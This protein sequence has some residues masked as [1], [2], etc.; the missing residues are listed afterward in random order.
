MF[1]NFQLIESR[2]SMIIFFT[3]NQL[4]RAL[5]TSQNY[6]NSKIKISNWVIEHSNPV[7]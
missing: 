1:K 2:L 4:I 3:Q 5:I 6:F 7:E